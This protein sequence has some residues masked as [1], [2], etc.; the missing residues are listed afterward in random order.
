MN[1]L[2]QYFR[3]SLTKGKGLVLSSR[4]HLPLRA[5]QR[6]Q[7]TCFYQGKASSGIAPALPDRKSPGLKSQH[8]EV[9]PGLHAQPRVR[10]LRWIRL[11]YLQCTQS[12]GLSGGAEAVL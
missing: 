1:A 9:T 6:A 11:R 4:R 12:T 3:T 10:H 8:K 5:L 2:G 7:N